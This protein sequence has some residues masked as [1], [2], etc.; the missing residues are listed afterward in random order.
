L[1]PKADDL[2]GDRPEIEAAKAEI[3]ARAK[4]EEAISREV[5]AAVKKLQRLNELNHYGESI[6]KAYGGR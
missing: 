4:S 1:L 6:R 3:E 5:R 2:V